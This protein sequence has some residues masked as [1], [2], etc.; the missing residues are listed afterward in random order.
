MRG[1]SVLP[2]TFKENNDFLSYI[3]ILALPMTNSYM[4]S[5]SYE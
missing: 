3:Y 4:L 5:K 2:D 1:V